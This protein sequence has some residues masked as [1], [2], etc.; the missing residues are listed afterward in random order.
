LIERQAVRGSIA[1]MDPI[2]FRANL[3]GLTDREVA[4]LRMVGRRLKRARHA[5]GWT[6][7]QLEGASGVDQ[8]T[9]SRVENGRQMGLG[10][11]KIAALAMALDGTW[12]FEAM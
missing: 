12:P 11:L 5:K 9:I 3:P 8:T 7:R 1:L 2:L 10:L 6:Q 4:A